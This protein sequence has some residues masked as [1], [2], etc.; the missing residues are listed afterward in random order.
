MKGSFGSLWF[1]LVRVGAPITPWIVR[2]YSEGGNQGLQISLEL[3]RE[4]ANVEVNVMVP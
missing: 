4:A 3:G 1:L 2:L